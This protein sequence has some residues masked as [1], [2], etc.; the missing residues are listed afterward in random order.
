MATISGTGIVAAV[1]DGHGGARYSR[2]HLGARFAVELAL[3]LT[4]TRL[5][6]L[7]ADP[8]E[9]AAD[10]L[11]RL[12]PTLVNAWRRRVLT[13]AERQPFDPAEA[14]PSSDEEV[15]MAYGATLLVALALPRVVVFAQLGDGDIIAHT[16]D[17]RT[18]RP[19]VS[20]PRLVASVTSSLCEPNAAGAFRAAYL[21]G[22]DLPALVVVSTDGYANSFATPDWDHRLATDLLSLIH[23]G[24]FQMVAADLASWAAASA[25]HA[26][27][28]VS[29]ALVNRWTVT[30]L[31]GG[32][33]E[34][35]EPWRPYR[36]GSEMGRS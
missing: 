23:E 15:V 30:P 21:T 12:A 14:A 3:Q 26:G 5:I 29:I 24:G 6:G 4:P 8:D 9:L 25:D 10:M 11:G 22:S 36:R 34:V 2:S 17:G 13:D 20:D 18:V 35:P 33:A 16:V 28:D 27:D 31:R 1:A 7:D 19:I 32:R